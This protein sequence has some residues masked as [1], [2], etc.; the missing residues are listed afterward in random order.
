M[1]RPDNRGRVV[2][3]LASSRPDLIEVDLKRP[4]RIDV[5]VPLFPTTS[6]ADGFQ[7]VR[8]LGLQYSLEFGDQAGLF[9]IPDLLT[10]GTAEA[11]VVKAYRLV[12][13]QGLAGAEALARCLEDY[14]SPVSR[15]A[16][17]LQIRLAIQEA[18][19]MDFVPAALRERFGR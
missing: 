15:E 7:L 13:T 3:V 12:Q 19:D 9:N 14:Q 10:P 17:E 8:E 4:G 2:W 11:L 16:M 6:A 18:S 1:S 5:K